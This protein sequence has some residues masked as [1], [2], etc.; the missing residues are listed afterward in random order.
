MLSPFFEADFFE[1]EHYTA[2]T[3]YKF[4][5]AV[6]QGASFVTQ[7]SSEFCIRDISRT[8]WNFT[9]LEKRLIKIMLN[10]SEALY[11]YQMITIVLFR[12]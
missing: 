4:V 5:N 1:P 2:L 7:L 10:F 9:F 6:K 11:H 3:D 8:I 12:A